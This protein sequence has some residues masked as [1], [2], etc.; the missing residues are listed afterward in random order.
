[1]KADAGK[2]DSALAE[3]AFES[4]KDRQALYSECIFLFYQMTGKLGCG[5]D[6][7]DLGAWLDKY[8]PNAF[9]AKGKRIKD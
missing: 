3:K 7:K 5:F 2:V 4:G 1:M 8:H 6:A 9:D